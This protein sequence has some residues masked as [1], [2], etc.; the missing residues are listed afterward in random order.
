ML[1]IV[2]G[3]RL[4]APAER[5]LV[6]T[7]QGLD[8]S[9]TLYIGYPIIGSTDEPVV[10]QALLTTMEHGVVVFDYSGEARLTEQVSEIGE[11]QNDL[12]AAIYQKLFASKSLRAGRHLAIPVR[13]VSLTP[14]DGAAAQAAEEETIITTA[15]DLPTVLAAFEPLSIEHYRAVNAA[16]QRIATI[17]PANKRAK[18]TKAGSRGAV[19][20]QIEREIANLDQWQKK[21]AIESPEGPQRIRGL[22]GSGKTVVL[23]LKAA[24]LHARNPQ[25]NIVV[26]FNTRALY[27]QLKDL[28]RRF[29]FEQ[30]NDEPDWTKLRLLHAWGSSRQAGIYSEIAAANVT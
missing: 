12:H 3:Q 20:Q 11:H 15:R 25:W 10:I 29:C 18:V 2:T 24:Y 16:I 8:L 17:K 14:I 4:N 26:T 30:L 6:T 9:G 22:A 5:D 13:V 1:E 28:I 23:A 7:L 27:Q 19:M 21:A